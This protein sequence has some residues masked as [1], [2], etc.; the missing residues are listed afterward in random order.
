MRPGVAPPRPS[1]RAP[2]APRVVPPAPPDGACDPQPRR[3]LPPPCSLRAP[4]PSPPPPASHIASSLRLTRSEPRRMACSFRTVPALLRA[5]TR[6]A[7]LSLRRSRSIARRRSAQD[8]ATAMLTTSRT[9]PASPARLDT[10]AITPNCPP[11]P[12]LYFS[13]PLHPLQLLISHILQLTC[14]TEGARSFI[15]FVH[16]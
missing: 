13:H 8:L 9:P 16:Y 11:S 3:L 10:A 2:R 14:S 12:S 15:R 5:P 4:P 1:R 6:G 7:P